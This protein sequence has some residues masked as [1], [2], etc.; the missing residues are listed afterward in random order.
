[1]QSNPKR[2]N[3][4][5]RSII[6][7]PALIEHG[8]RFRLHS[9]VILLLSPSL[10]HAQFRH[11]KTPSLQDT[12]R[13]GTSRIWGNVPDGQEKG[14]YAWESPQW[15]RI[16]FSPDGKF[17]PIRIASRPNGAVVCLWRSEQPSEQKVKNE[18]MPSAGATAVSR[19][20]N[21]Y[22]RDYKV[23]E[24]QGQSS[25][26]IAAF[27]AEWEWYPVL[28]AAKNDAWITNGGREIYRIAG[29]QAPA[30]QAP[31][32]QPSTDQPS[33][34][35]AK[36]SSSRISS[37]P[38]KPIYKL[39]T[40][41]L[42]R[43]GR[44]KDVKNSMNPLRAVSDGQGRLW[45]FSDLWSNGSNHFMLRGALIWDGKQFIYRPRLTGQSFDPTTVISTLAYKDATHLWLAQ[46][47]GGFYKP[48]ASDL[49]E[50]NTNTFETRLVAQPYP[51]AFQD[52]Q[53]ITA[54]G[55]DWYLVAGSRWGSE[56]RYDDGV[57]TGNLW[58]LRNGQ[59]RLLI[60]GLDKGGSGLWS[61]PQQT[62]RPF[63]ETAQGLWVGAFGGGMWFIPRPRASAATPASKAKG[64]D[65]ETSAQQ[66]VVQTAGQAVAMDWQRGLPFHT[67]D[68][69]FDIGRGQVLAHSSQGTILVADL[70]ALLARKA[71]PRARTFRTYCDLI[72]SRN[73]HLWGVLSLRGNA[74][75]EWD[76]GRWRSYSAPPHYDLNWAAECAFDSR[77]RIWLLPGYSD[78]QAAIFDPKT[79]SWKVFDTYRAALQAQMRKTGKRNILTAYPVFDRVQ[80]RTGV[81][82][83]QVPDFRSDGQICYRGG[84]Q[85]LW[86]FDG[87]TWR[88]WT[89]QQIT[90][91]AVGGWD[92]FEAPFFDRSGQL[93]VNIDDKTWKRIKISGSGAAVWKSYESEADPRP[94]ARHH[95]PTAVVSPAGTSFAS[96]AEHS[97][98]RSPDSKIGDSKG[99]VWIIWQQHLYKTAP[100]LQSPQFTPKDNHPFLDGRFFNQVFVDNKGNTF[101]STAYGFSEYVMIAGTAPP[102]TGIKI[103]PRAVDAF[104]FEFSSTATGQ[105]W[106]RWRTDDEPWSQPQTSSR[107]QLDAL[108][109]G[110]HRIQAMA[111]DRNLLSDPSPA[112]AVFLVNIDPAKQVAAFIG[113]LSSPDYSRREAAVTGLAKQPKRALPTL[114][115]ARVRASES[116]RWW[117][118]AAIQQ[119]E[120]NAHRTMAK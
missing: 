29:D 111:I 110:L 113:E 52:I 100:G 60:S 1:M 89:R 13:D 48:R 99:F 79:M 98:V 95:D 84:G 86:Y 15:R 43:T 21:Q 44:T 18:A 53:Q 120:R 55:R 56:I 104:T 76:G 50:L 57:R 40:T 66:A 34:L 75:N 6:L 87:R 101:F 91:E 24:H 74:L 96:T 68:Q 35:L 82:P 39:G 19:P 102:D 10:A 119:I 49:Y 73:G 27:T 4:R 7:L 17:A 58:R 88:P 78:R 46:S 109:G 112:S 92:Y 64:A 28:I 93:S 77:G 85:R 51:Q 107:V 32:G 94:A 5:C 9:V 62:P 59:W 61:G 80:T 116:S 38:L 30:G 117:I 42:F 54:V 36:A 105:K 90:K 103:T 67:T 16:D 3:V 11:I 12:A 72:Q 63:L 22:L 14:L 115:A 45:F 108:P 47:T 26:F 37:V 70:P 71:S 33:E 69:L 83:Y 20:I 118:D 8:R 41:Q 65:T 2:R 97:P 25:R 114:K 23:S 81:T 106:Y 31:V